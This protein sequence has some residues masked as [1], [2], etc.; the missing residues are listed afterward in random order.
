MGDG[1]P[2]LAIIAD[3]P[4]KTCKVSDDIAANW[5]L[6]IQITLDDYHLVAVHHRKKYNMNE[7]KE[8]Y[9]FGAHDRH[10]AQ[11]VHTRDTPAVMAAQCLIETAGRMT[12]E[13]STS[14]PT[15]RCRSFG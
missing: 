13:Y 2:I 5:M 8:Y 4:A 6:L 15:S 14:F 10:S 7:E 3:M 12:T 9:G 1:F 11:F